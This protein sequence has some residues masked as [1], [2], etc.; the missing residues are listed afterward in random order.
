MSQT[1]CDTPL[2]Y[3]SFQLN[4]GRNL[5]NS[6]SHF[7]YFPRSISHG[8]LQL[9]P[10]PYSAPLLYRYFISAN[11]SFSP[12]VH[13]SSVYPSSECYFDPFHN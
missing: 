12:T 6:V 4:R 8:K 2:D 11:S 3:E 13:R 9:G 5:F 1:I 10:D 7:D